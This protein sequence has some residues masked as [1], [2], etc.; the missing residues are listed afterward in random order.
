[1]HDKLEMSLLYI[2]IGK[3]IQYIYNHFVKMK[4]FLS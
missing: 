1:L 4:D 2:Q 3:S